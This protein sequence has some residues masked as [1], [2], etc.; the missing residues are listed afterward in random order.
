MRMNCEWKRKVPNYIAQ[1]KRSF[2][3]FYMGIN[4]LFVFAQAKSVRFCFF[5]CKIVFTHIMYYIGSIYS[6][7][8]IKFNDEVQNSRFPLKSH[9]EPRA[10][11]L[12]TESELDKSLFT[13]LMLRFFQS[14]LIYRKCFYFAVVVRYW[15]LLLNLSILFAADLDTGLGAGERRLCGKQCWNHNKKKNVLDRI[16]YMGDGKAEAYAHWVHIDSNETWNDQQVT[17]PIW[18]KW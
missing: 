13:F 10:R 9:T 11:S 14:D 15:A 4:C 2:I 7:E 12:Q 6:F 8:T 18:M 5:Y 1:W 3:A 17:H 16:K